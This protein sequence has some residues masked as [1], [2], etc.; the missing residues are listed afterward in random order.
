MSVNNKELDSIKTIL[1]KLPI[2][3]IFRIYD[4]EKYVKNNWKAEI[5]WLG[6]HEN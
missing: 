3:K 5:N 6:K 1:K 2:K 4:S